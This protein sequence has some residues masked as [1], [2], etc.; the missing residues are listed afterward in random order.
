MKQ[1][2]GSVFPAIL[3]GAVL[4]LAPAAALAQMGGPVYFTP[5]ILYSHQM[6]GDFQ[7]RES[8]PGFTIGSGQY[9]G[10]SQ[11]DD[12]YGGGLAVGYDFGA[13]GALPVRAELEYLLRSR[14]STQYPTKTTANVDP[15]NYM[16]TSYEAYAT[17]QTVFANLYYDFRNDTAFTPYIGAGL[18]GAYVKGELNTRHTG[19]ALIPGEF[20]YQ[21]NSA[22]YGGSHNTWNFAW[23]LNA[24]A[25]YHLTDN[26]ALDLSYRYSDLGT[27]EY[28]TYGYEARNAAGDKVGGYSG[29]AEAD[30]ATHEVILGLRIS[31]F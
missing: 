8:F 30:L 18:G 24:G 9:S 11:S 12:A 25:A 29:K 1:S 22:K 13:T 5:K 28:G 7:A 4:L 17:A 21:P 15:F 14:S 3:A 20:N 27:V 26:V 2:I 6:I 19:Q 23:N 10:S 16:D 31:A